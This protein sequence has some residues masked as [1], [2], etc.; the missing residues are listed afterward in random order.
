MNIIASLNI[1]Y[2]DGALEFT[3][4]NGVTIELPF[5][6]IS[7]LTAAVPNSSQVLPNGLQNLRSNLAPKSLLTPVIKAATDG[8]IINFTEALQVLDWTNKGFAN[9]NLAGE[10]PLK[11][12]FPEYWSFLE[13]YRA[14]IGDPNAI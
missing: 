9:V 4:D 14:S 5:A 12:K 10:N 1:K 3:L 7:K 13:Q 2:E 8:K 6:E 11:D